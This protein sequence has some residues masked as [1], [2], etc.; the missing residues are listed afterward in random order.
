MRPWG[1]SFSE[2][3]RETEEMMVASIFSII[4]QIKFLWNIL[5]F[6]SLSAA[7]LNS[8][9]FF[10]VWLGEKVKILSYDYLY[11][12]FLPQLFTEFQDETGKPDLWSNKISVII[13]S[14]FNYRQ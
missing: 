2:T 8:T 12:N 4:L 13:T 3:L 11:A 5:F 9:G 14:I 6:S 7:A 1:K 10:S